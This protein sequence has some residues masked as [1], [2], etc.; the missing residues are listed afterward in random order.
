MPETR[1]LAAMTGTDGAPAA[2][3]EA[4]AVVRETWIERFSPFN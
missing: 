1:T 4:W 3:A 2:Q